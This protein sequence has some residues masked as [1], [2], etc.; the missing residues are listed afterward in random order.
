MTAPAQAV[1]TEA[2]IAALKALE[3]GSEMMTEGVSA[4][5]AELELSREEP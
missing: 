2:P 3:P 5:P 1:A 4:I